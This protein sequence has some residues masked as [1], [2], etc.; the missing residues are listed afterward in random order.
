LIRLNWIGESSTNYIGKVFSN[1]DVGHAR[2]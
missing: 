1:T 2:L